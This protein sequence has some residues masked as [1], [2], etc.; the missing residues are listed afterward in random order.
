MGSRFRCVSSAVAA[1]PAG[2]VSPR[3]IA[4][5]RAAGGPESAYAMLATGFRTSSGTTMSMA[6]PRAAADPA[7][8]LKSAH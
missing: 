8:P 1:A 2:I 5:Q 6:V 7:H 4:P 3:S